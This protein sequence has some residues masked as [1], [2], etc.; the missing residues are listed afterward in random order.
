MN[1]TES[2]H[3]QNVMAYLRGDKDMSVPGVRLQ[4]AISLEHLEGAAR[5]RMG[6]GQHDSVEAWEQRLTPPEDPS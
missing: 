3:T 5:K 6:A 1:V 2:I 4:T